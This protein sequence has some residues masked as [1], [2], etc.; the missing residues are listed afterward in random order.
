MV[1]VVG[2]LELEGSPN[3]LRDVVDLMPR[4]GFEETFHFCPDI[5]GRPVVAV[6]RNIEDTAHN[7]PDRRRSHPALVR[8]DRNHRIPQ[9][10]G[11][12]FANCDGH[13]AAGVAVAF[14]E[15]GHCGFLNAF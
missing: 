5:F 8:R 13:V 2:A 14:G 15:V 1:F 10:G 6:W 9:L 7:R 12:I 4:A 11:C 3:F